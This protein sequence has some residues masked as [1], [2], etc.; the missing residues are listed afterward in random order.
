MKILQKTLLAAALLAATALPGAAAECLKDPDSLFAHHSW[1]VKMSSGCWVGADAKPA[2]RGNRGHHHAKRKEVVRHAN[3]IR[4][5]QRSPLETRPRQPLYIG[6]G[7]AVT[8]V[9]RPDADDLTSA[10]NRCV[11]EWDRRHDKH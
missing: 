4:S 3:G 11:E 10:L 7:G 1:A 8:P 6:V 9:F 5:G 2:T